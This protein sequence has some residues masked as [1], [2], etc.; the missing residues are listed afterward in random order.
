MRF[1][2]L[3]GGGTNNQVSFLSGLWLAIFNTD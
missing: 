1:L 2:M 3:H